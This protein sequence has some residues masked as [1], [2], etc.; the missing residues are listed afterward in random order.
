MHA[1]VWIPLWPVE[2]LRSHGFIKQQE[3]VAVYDHNGIVSFDSKA[4]QL[5]ISYGMKKRYAKAS[6]PEIELVRRRLD[7]ENFNFEKVMKACENFVS[8]LT[9]LRPGM[10]IFQTRGAVRMFGSQEKLAE[11]ILGKIT[12]DTGHEAHIGFGE[13]TLCAILAAY[14]D[15]FVENAQTYLDPLP[16]EA[17]EHACF[18]P[19]LQAQM[20]TFIADLQLLGIATLAD[21]RALDKSLLYSRFG[22]IAQFAFSL[23]ELEFSLPEQKE[24]LRRYIAVKRNLDPP[25]TNSESFAF[26]ARE[27]GNELVQLLE[28]ESC[29]AKELCVYVRTSDSKELSRTWH[30]DA[31]DVPTIVDRTRWQL[32]VWMEQ[33]HESDSDDEGQSVTYLEIRAQSLFPAGFSQ[34]VLWGR[35]DSYSELAHKAINRLQALVGQEKVLIPTLKAQLAPNTAYKLEP[36]ECGNNSADKG[37]D[38]SWPGAIPRPWPRKILETY[39]PI[40]ICDV[41]GHVCV[42]NSLGRFYCVHG[43]GFVEP[44]FFNSQRYSGEINSYS[45]PWLHRRQWWAPKKETDHVWCEVVLDDLHAFL[46]R[47]DSAGWRLVGE[48]T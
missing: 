31:V 26:L 16:V 24:E 28:R 29:F 20:K 43:C 44:V 2:T 19:K 18:S 9:I 11:E 27:L 22:Y 40:T 34:G 42:V 32:K 1:V 37:K 47:W 39:E 13:G 10:L 23:L 12:E 21:L 15:Q 6:A 35:E 3:G 36:W 41:Q 7:L 8:S 25:V 5:G 17:L 48:Y 46:C 14:N 4:A 30:L 45:A 38:G 33:L